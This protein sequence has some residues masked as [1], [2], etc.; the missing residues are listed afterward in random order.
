MAVSLIS[1]FDSYT[2]VVVRCGS[3]KTFYVEEIAGIF[4]QT[5]KFKMPNLYFWRFPPNA[6]N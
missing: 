2:Y 4:H 3:F 6:Q 5:K 1:F